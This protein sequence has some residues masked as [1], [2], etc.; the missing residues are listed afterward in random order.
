MSQSGH[1]LEKSIPT[2][3]INDEKPLIPVGILFIEI[4]KAFKAKLKSYVRID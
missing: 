2:G 1:V 3:K 4:E